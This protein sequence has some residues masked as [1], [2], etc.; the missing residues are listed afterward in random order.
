[1]LT[2]ISLSFASTSSNV[3][4]YLIEFWLI[5]SAEVATPPALAAFAGPKRIPAFWN[6]STAS[7]VEGIFAPSATAITPFAISA[8]AD[9]P[10]SSF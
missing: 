7:G 3:Q 8:F 10:S 4:L 9:S 6:A 2:I 1:M 5:S